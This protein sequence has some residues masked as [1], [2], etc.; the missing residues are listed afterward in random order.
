[1]G[2]MPRYG[3]PNFDANWGT[4]GPPIYNMPP[5]FAPSSELWVETKTEDGKSYYYHAMTRETTWTKP[6]GP[7]IQIMTQNEV[8]AMTASKQ[9]SQQQPLLQQQTNIAPVAT[10]SVKGGAKA[11]EISNG[12]A[13]EVNADEIKPQPTS[14]NNEKLNELVPFKPPHQGAHIMA[15]PG[16]MPPQITPPF[17]SPP[18][19][20]YGN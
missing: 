15:P 20:Q 3:N 1:M 6:E 16:Q 2:P 10:E 11:P 18:P 19:F 17:T 4:N 14:P 9:Q 5:N 13:N 12:D 7:H 8:E